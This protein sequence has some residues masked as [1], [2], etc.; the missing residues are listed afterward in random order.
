MEETKQIRGALYYEMPDELIGVVQDYYLSY[1]IS[2]PIKGVQ[3][4]VK[5][6]N[7][8]PRGI[9]TFYNAAAHR[10][11]LIVCDYSNKKLHVYNISSGVGEEAYSCNNVEACYVAANSHLNQI[12]Y[13][14]E[15]KISII[16]MKTQKSIRTLPDN[17][18]DWIHDVYYNEVCD[19]FLVSNACNRQILK[20]KSNGEYV[21][22]INVNFIPAGVCSSPITNHLYIADHVG[23]EVGCLSMSGDKLDSYITRSPRYIAINVADPEKNQEELVIC[24]L[25]YN[26]LC[27]RQLGL[28]Q[29][30]HYMTCNSDFNGMALSQSSQCLMLTMTNNELILVQ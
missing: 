17:K 9:T 26:D 10:E 15:T 24:S 6:L 8:N 1:P 5:Q 3:K 20:Y 16:D 28:D 27:I 30:T 19:L 7:Y 13:T 22:Q 18:I 25:F 29:V 12:M 21:G 2:R 11:E 14:S 23:N 4:Q